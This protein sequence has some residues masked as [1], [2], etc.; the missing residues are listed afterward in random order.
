MRLAE[1]EEASCFGVGTELH[2]HPV[3][4]WDTPL[5]HVQDEPVELL[6]PAEVTKKRRN[7]QRLEWDKP[8]A[9]PHLFAKVLSHVFGIQ[10]LKCG[11]VG[12]PPG[13]DVIMSWCLSGCASTMYSNTFRYIPLKHNLHWKAR[14]L[15]RL[16]LLWSLR[17]KNNAGQQCNQH[18]TPRQNVKLSAS[19]CF[20]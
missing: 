15:S 17:C 16:D 9:W 6:L 5:F 14:I 3:P 10:D 13:H 19:E 18:H 4:L 2:V 8:W 20:S 7:L 11:H 12:K 1:T